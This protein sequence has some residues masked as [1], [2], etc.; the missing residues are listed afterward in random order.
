MGLGCRA[1][2]TRVSVYLRPNACFSHS[3]LPLT[4]NL[5]L[6]RTSPF[7]NELTSLVPGSAIHDQIIRV[8]DLDAQHTEDTAFYTHL[9]SLQ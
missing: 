4:T 9:L 8:K 1:L 7:Q 6:D 2:C 5:R 3:V